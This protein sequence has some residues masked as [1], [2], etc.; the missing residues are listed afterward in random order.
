[1]PLPYNKRT[2]YCAEVTKATTS[3]RSVLLTGWVDVRR[4]HGGMVFIDLR[5]RTGL[6]QLKCNPE[7]DPVAHTE[8]PARS[9]TS[10]ASALRGDVAPRPEGLVNPKLATGAIEVNVREIDDPEHGP[11]PPRSRSSTRST[12]TRRRG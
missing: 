12:P 5:D 1:V 10:S 11:T 9:A 3:A 6:V 2:C 8:S 7:T 4:D